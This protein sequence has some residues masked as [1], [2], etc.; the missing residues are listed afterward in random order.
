MLVM[1][2]ITIVG[3]LLSIALAPETRGLTLAQA[4]S[5]LPSDKEVKSGTAEVGE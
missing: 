4:A 3:L 5:V 2:A 1:A